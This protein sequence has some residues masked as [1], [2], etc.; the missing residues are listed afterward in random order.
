MCA[1][2]CAYVCDYMVLKV[3]SCSNRWWSHKEALSE[4]GTFQA[5]QSPT[6]ASW[7]QKRSW[8]LTSPAPTQGGL[9]RI[10][11]GHCDC[12][13][14]GVQRSEEPGHCPLAACVSLAGSLPSLSPGECPPPGAAGKQKEAIDGVLCTQHVLS[15]PP[16][17]WR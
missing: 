10:P 9:A 8:P 12:K 14:L 3:P 6:P 7:L 13:S 1:C 15:V 4:T 2:V 5:P 11:K 16:G 17:H